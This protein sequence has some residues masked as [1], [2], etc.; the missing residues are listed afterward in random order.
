MGVNESGGHDGPG[1]IEDRS[2]RPTRRHLCARSDIDDDVTDNDDAA[3]SITVGGSAGTS[4]VPPS[5][6]RSPIRIRAGIRRSGGCG[7]RDGDVLMTCTGCGQARTGDTF[8]ASPPRCDPA[9]GYVRGPSAR[10]RTW[11]V[12]RDVPRRQIVRRPSPPGNPSATSC[13]DRPTC[14]TLRRSALVVQ[15]GS[16]RRPRSWLNWGQTRAPGRDCNR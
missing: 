12:R 10:A 14:G 6:S 15:D 2:A 5:I 16:R 8:A 1:R 3:S 9:S 13:S 4:T 7:S 11:V